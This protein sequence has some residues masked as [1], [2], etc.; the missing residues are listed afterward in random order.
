[1]RARTAPRWEASRTPAACPVLQEHGAMQQEST[2]LLYANLAPLVSTTLRPALRRVS[3][4][5]QVTTAPIP[6]QRRAWRVRSER[7]IRRLV[8]THRPCAFPAPPGHMGLGPVPRRLHRAQRA[9][10]ARTA[11]RSEPSQ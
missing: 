10:R 5:A 1:M 7:T 9:M 8:R 6:V 2:R 11:P 4:A 3:S